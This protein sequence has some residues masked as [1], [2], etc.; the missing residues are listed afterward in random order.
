MTQFDERIVRDPEIFQE[1]RL[2]AHSDHEWYTTR[3]K[4]E[5]GLI[6]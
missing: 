4:A 5:E 1:N 6:L 3:E 2:P